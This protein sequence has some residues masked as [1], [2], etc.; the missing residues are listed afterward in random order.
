MNAANGFP[1]E[2]M[3]EVWAEIEAHR[4]R[5]F[6]DDLVRGAALLCEEAGE[7]IQAALD[8]TRAA[9][10]GRWKG[11][12]EAVRQEAKQTAAVAV[13]LMMRVDKEKK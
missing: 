2:I 1:L 12:V 7:T 9:G 4:D 3:K 6:P 13:L 5:V 8:V 10:D 11:G